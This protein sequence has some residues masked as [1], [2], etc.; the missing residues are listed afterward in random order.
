MDNNAKKINIEIFRDIVYVDNIVKTLNEGKIG[1]I[2]SLKF[3]INANDHYPEHIHIMR[4]SQ[5]LARIDLNTY[6]LMDGSNISKS[7]YRKAVTWIKD[8][9]KGGKLIQYF[10]DNLNE[11]V[12]IY[13]Y[14]N[15]DEKVKFSYNQPQILHG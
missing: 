9:N 4:K 11:S 15:K 2:D 8:N 3:S 7:D 1:Q 12:L 10:R 6:E 13:I 14:K 5:T